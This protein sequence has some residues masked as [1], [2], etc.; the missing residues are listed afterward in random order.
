MS[1][2]FFVIIYLILKG[3]MMMKIINSV[4][5]FIDKV[6]RNKN[7]YTELEFNSIAQSVSIKYFRKFHN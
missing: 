4:N 2:V 5:S 6:G 3:D 7:T 1:V